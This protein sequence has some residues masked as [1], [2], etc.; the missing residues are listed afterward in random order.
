[1][2]GMETEEGGKISE[3]FRFGNTAHE[4]LSLIQETAPVV[5]FEQ[6]RVLTVFTK[7]AH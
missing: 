5:V 7:P 6:F 4:L 2:L 3:S 1:M